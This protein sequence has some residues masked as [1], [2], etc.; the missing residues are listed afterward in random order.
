M[1]VELLDAFV[2]QLNE[3]IDYI[4]R[5]KPGAARKFKNDILNQTKK[6][7]KNPMLHRQSIYFENMQYRDMIFKGYKVVLKIDNEK[8]TVFVIGLVN[9]QQRIG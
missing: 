6:L 8:D 2:E 4:A 3:Q 1:K 7:A 5:D 9:T